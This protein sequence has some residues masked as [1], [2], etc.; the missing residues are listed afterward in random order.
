MELKSYNNDFH[1]RMINVSKSFGENKVLENFNL[2]VEKGNFLTILGPSGCGKTTTL[3]LL[4]GFLSLDEGE[5][6]IDDKN[7]SQLPSNKRNISMVFQNYA[8]FP[9]MTVYDN[10]AFGL[11]LRKVDENI[12]KNRV[13]D[14]LNLV[15]LDFDTYKDRYPHQLSGGEQQRVSF[16]RA[17]IIEPKVLL[18]DEPLSNLDAKLR[19]N[20]RV[21]IKKIHEKTGVTI[22]YVTHDQEEA[23]SISSNI[24]VL[25]KGKNVQ[26]GSP[27]QIFCNPKSTFVADFIGNS[28]FL[29]GKV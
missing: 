12:I 24:V 6:W 8:L 26:M 7:V 4:A 23:L 14:M 28:N 10:V 21:E 15:G 22:I 5:I 17:L 18:L 16:A 25:N 20:M 29:K 9:H 19:N 3:N 13:I 1:I 2:N 27:E 11:K